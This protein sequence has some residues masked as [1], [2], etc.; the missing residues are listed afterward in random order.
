VPITANNTQTSRRRFRFARPQTFGHRYLHSP[1]A[2]DLTRFFSVSAWPWGEIP[3]GS[4]V[5]AVHGGR[6]ENRQIWLRKMA[7]NGVCLSQLG[8]DLD[9]FTRGG[10][11]LMRDALVLGVRRLE[12]LGP[13]LGRRLIYPFSA[14]VPCAESQPLSA[15]R[16]TSA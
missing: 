8:G 12:T 6:P 10:C 11:G 14:G 16:S 2:R 4:V 7:R 5:S 13:S 3:G 1:A 15:G 9:V